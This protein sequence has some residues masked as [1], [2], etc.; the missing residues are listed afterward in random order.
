M[1]LSTSHIESKNFSKQKDF[2]TLSSPK[3]N[4]GDLRKY[5]R[6]V[7][8]ETREKFYLES[9][10][11]TRIARRSMRTEKERAWEKEKAYVKKS[12]RRLVII[13]K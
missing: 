9:Q 10:N 12:D 3:L 11:G 8:W 1:L 7:A 6:R 2:S 13:P 4:L 5:G